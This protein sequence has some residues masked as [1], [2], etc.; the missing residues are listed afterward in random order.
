MKTSPIS[1]GVAFALLVVCI[2]NIGCRHAPEQGFIPKKELPLY[3]VP[4]V[5][6]IF[7]C[8]DGDVKRPGRYYLD[9]G[10][11]LESFYHSFG[12]YGGRS[13]FSGPR[14]VVLTRTVNGRTTQSYYPVRTMTS[15]EKEAVT[16]MDG[17][18][19]HYPIII[20]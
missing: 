15:P 10:A 1:L 18:K 5:G 8:V 17:D 12:G 4:G 3:G 13:D 19:L 11:K 9:E 16:L 7:V 2:F 20:F 14:G 6:K